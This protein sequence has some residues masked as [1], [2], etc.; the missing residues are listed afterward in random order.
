MVLSRGLDSYFT[1][2]VGHWC[3]LSKIVPGYDQTNWPCR[4]AYLAIIVKIGASKMRPINQSVPALLGIYKPILTLYEQHQGY[5][6][7]ILVANRS[8]DWAYLYGLTVQSNEQ[9]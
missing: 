5:D 1:G 4:W 9:S 2:L 7:F 3:N 8:I 6:Q